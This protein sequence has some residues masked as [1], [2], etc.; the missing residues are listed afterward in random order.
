DEL[1]AE[2]ARSNTEWLDGLGNN[3][4]LARPRFAVVA[5][6]TPTEGF[7]TPE[8]ENAFI[9]SLMEENKME[10]YGFRIN[11]IAWLKPRDKPIGKHGS[12]AIWF[13][14][15]EAAEWTMDNGLLVGQ[16]CIGVTPYQF[17]ERRCYRCQGFGHLA[18][19]CREKARC[20]HCAGEHELRHCPPGA[21]ARCLDCTGEHPTND[22]S[23]PNPAKL[24]NSQ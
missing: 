14:T 17:K 11:R 4:K 16:R 1:Q 12:L 3:T 2:T 10:L 15:R 19:A 9:G 13:D 20:G 24:T 5:H 6:R 23:C 7:L 8:D 21:R 18:W 22:R